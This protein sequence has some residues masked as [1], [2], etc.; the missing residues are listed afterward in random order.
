VDIL[1]PELGLEFASPYE[2]V[3]ATAEDVIVLLTTL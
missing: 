2:K 1:A 3:E